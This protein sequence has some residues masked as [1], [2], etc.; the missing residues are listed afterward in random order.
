MGFG[1]PA[2]R[3][4][5]GRLRVSTTGLASG[6]P[7][8][9]GDRGRA[10]SHR[11]GAARAALR[12]RGPRHRTSAAARNPTSGCARSPPTATWRDAACSRAHSAAVLLGA[13]CAPEDAPAEATVPGGGQREH[14]GLLVHRGALAADDVRPC[15]GV[16]VTSG[17]RTALRPRATA[18]ASSTPSSGS[19]PWR[20][21]AAST[22]PTSSP[23]RTAVRAHGAA[24]TC[25]GPSRWPTGARA[26]RWR[27]ACELILVSGGL[28]VPEVQYPCWTTSGGAPC[29]WISPTRHSASASSTRVPTTPAPRRVLLDAGRYTRLADAGWRIYRFTEVPRVRRAGR[30]RRD[31]PSRAFAAS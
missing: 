16:Q 4:R 10:R 9:R 26:P 29:G 28:P 30:D 19:T 8:V 31:D 24:A 18:R 22:P 12:P 6:V 13:D 5:P 17:V 14:P 25:G 11:Q 21:S 20:T 1:H 27:P 7:R 15:R 23:W 2:I 3:V